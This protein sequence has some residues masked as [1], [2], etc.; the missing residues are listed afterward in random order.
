MSGALRYTCTIRFRVHARH[1]TTSQ[2]G[3]DLIGIGVY[4]ARDS[5]DACMAMLADLRS[6]YDHGRRIDIVAFDVRSSNSPNDAVPPG[7]FAVGRAS[8][9][10]R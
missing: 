9:A 10:T 7:V 3:D 1:N 5:E 8:D 4:R 2:V 6:V